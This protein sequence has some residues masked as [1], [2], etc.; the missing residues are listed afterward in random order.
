M[1]ELSRSSQ[2]P[3]ATVDL[4]SIAATSSRQKTNQ[5]E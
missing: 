3:L 4:T 2:D 5:P 1:Q